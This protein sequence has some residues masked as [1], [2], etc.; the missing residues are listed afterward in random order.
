[1]RDGGGPLNGLSW[2]YLGVFDP[3]LHLPEVTGRPPIHLVGHAFA[4]AGILLVLST[5][6]DL[7]RGVLYPLSRRDRADAVW[8]SSLRQ[9]LALLV[10]MAVG[11]ACAGL[12]AASAAEID[13]AARRVPEFLMAFAVTA[14]CLPA[15]QALRLR[16]FDSGVAPTDPVAYGAF[17]AAGGGLFALVQSLILVPL[18][19]A[20]PIPAAILTLVAAPLVVILVQHLY[21]RLLQSWFA[22]ADLT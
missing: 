14:V 12:V 19:E 10:V 17:V 3:R 21:R 8:R 15:L 7:R 1:M 18:R 2:V 6:L 9:G 22:T 20:D 11:F 5:R 13:L 16:F 4:L